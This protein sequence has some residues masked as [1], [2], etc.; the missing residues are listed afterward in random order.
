MANLNNIGEA[1]EQLELVLSF[2]ERAES[3]ALAIFAFNAT[4]LAL[5]FVNITSATFNGWW[6]VVIFAATIF[7]I[8]ISFLRVY[9]A[10][11]PNLEGDENS[12]IYF[13][14][15]SRYSRED[16][17]NKCIQGTEAD[18]LSD[19]LTQIWINSKIL[20]YKFHRVKIAF[21]I[22]L[23]TLFPWLVLMALITYK[24]N[25]ALKIS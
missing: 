18:L 5:L 21:Q 4:L 13:G 25:F 17:I 11:F 12:L 9:E 6:S 22:T 3:K 14:A 1:K 16:Y 8:G 15:I 20:S 19:Y 24:T 7:G 23:G 2:F 10:I